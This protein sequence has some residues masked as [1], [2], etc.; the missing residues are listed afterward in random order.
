ME[1]YGEAIYRVCR[2]MVAD[3]DLAEDV[4]QLTFVQAYAGLEAFADRSS[5]KSWLY[6]IARHRC[7]DAVS[8]RRRQLRLVS[9]VPELPDAVDPQAD[10]EAGVAETG[11]WKGVQRCLEEL[12]P[13]ARV[14]VLLRFHSGLSYPEMAEACGERSA[15]LHA[16][17]ARALPVL[18]RCLEGWG[19][20]P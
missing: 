12:A 17:V 7:L 13:R 4:H 14:A 5:L 15:T 19:I 18:R 6:G 16:R 11:F 1:A 3:A 20:A 8:S 9:A 2:R 10:P